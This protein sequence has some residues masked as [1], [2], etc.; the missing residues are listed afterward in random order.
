VVKKLVSIIITTRNEELNIERLLKS[1]KKQT[2]SG[3]EILVID[4]ASTDNTKKI[5]RR[6]TK[7]V[8]NKGPERS[9]QRNFGAKKALGEYLMFLDADMELTP[10]VVKQCVNEMEKDGI[11][12]ELCIAE[13]PVANSFWEKVKAFERSFYSLEGDS[14]T[15]AAR[16]FKK[17]IFWQLNGFDEKITGPEDWDLTERVISAGF[18]CG[19]ISEKIRHYENVPNPYKL[20]QKKYYY[21]L[22]SHRYFARHK[23]PMISAKTIYFLRPVFYKNWKRLIQ[24]PVLSMGLFVMFSFELAGGAFGY[25]IGRIKKL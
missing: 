5:A 9:A 6:Y 3:I 14:E 11:V 13:E 20:A 8:Y 7:L 4:N 12:G 10:D 25:L 1:I 15:D 23:V 18:E 17:K 24:H 2:Y 21:G 22:K 19:W 16:F